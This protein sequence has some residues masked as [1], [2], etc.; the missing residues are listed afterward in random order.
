MNLRRPAIVALA[1]STVALASTGAIAAEDWAAVVGGGVDDRL[2]KRLEEGVRTI[3]GTDTRFLIGGFV[4]LDGLATRHEQTGAE[5]ATFL[6]S[7]TPFGP[8]DSD[9]RLSIR[10]SQLNWLSS[11]PTALGPLALNAQANL[12]SLD[13]DGTTTLSLQRLYARLADVLV[14]GRTYST[15]VDP[16][17]LPTTLDYN[18]PSGLTSVQQWL[19]RGVLPLG[20]G[21]TFAA[22]AEQAQADHRVG[23]RSVELRTEAQRPDLA[24]HLRFDFERGHLQLSGVSRRIEITASAGSDTTSRTF[25]ASGL[26]ISGSV[27]TVGDDSLLAQ[28]TTGKGIGRYF[29]DSISGTGFGVGVDDRLQLV[30]SSGATLYYQRHWNADW[31]SVAGASTLWG[32]ETGTRPPDA[33]RRLVYASANIVH[34]LLPTLLV[35]AEGLWGKATRADGVGASNARL[36]LSVR[37]LVE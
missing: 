12:F 8:A 4:E 14:A 21:W 9:R 33:L 36:Q 20:S 16:D 37:Y 15:F 27:A 26:S 22:G 35:G 24:A 19:V 13:L 17:V 6:V 30:R 1:A 25:G 28:Y 18:G 11:T 23:R 31:M 7:S 3:P 34:R 29:N 32:S 5:Q 10:Q 2:A